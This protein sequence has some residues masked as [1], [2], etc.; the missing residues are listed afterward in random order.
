MRTPEGFS[1]PSNGNIIPS[2]KVN[3]V[4]RHT[5]HQLINMWPKCNPA[6]VHL[7]DKLD[8]VFCTV[9]VLHM[10]NVVVATCT[11]LQS[12]HVSLPLLD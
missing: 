3:P 5:N 7:A 1:L 12:I 9:G 8:V 10:T 2:S 11:L 4:V 6:K